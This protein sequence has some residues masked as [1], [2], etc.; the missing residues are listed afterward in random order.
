M[1]KLRK[2]KKRNP[3]IKKDQ[4]TEMFEFTRDEVLHQDIAR[5][6]WRGTSGRDIWADIVIGVAI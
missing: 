5:G 4:D 1:P 6:G 3:S 2:G